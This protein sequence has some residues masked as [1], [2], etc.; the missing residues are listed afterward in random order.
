MTADPGEG[1]DRAGFIVT[2]VAVEAIPVVYQPVLESSIGMLCARVP[3]LVAIY[4][5]GSVA[6]GQACPPGSDVDLLVVVSNRVDHRAMIAT[7]AEL[8]ALHRGVARDVGI[9]VVT[10]TQLWADDLDGLGGRCFVKHYCVP[11]HGDDVRPRLPRCLASPQVAWAF[12]HDTSVAVADAQRRLDHAATPE[13][14]R[15]VCRSAARKVTL[16]AAS[17]ASIIEP[18]W[19]T[20][21]NRAAQVITARHPEWARGAADRAQLVLITDRLP[22]RRVRVLHGFASW[23]ASELAL[24]AARHNATGSDSATSL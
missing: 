17:L 12:N 20:D 18:T 3:D 16:S 11:L 21:R 4:L 22:R 23:V 7:A 15:E 13:E 19:T 24:Q 2:G 8:S 9:A 14:V 1:I 10:L 5:Y 6:T